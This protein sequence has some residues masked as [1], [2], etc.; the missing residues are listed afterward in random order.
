MIFVTGAT[1]VGV[2]LGA[3][4]VQFVARNV[5]EWL[6]LV[7]G[8]ASLFFIIPGLVAIW[9]SGDTMLS[10]AVSIPLA[11]VCLVCGIGAVLKSYRT[12]RV[13]LGIGLAAIP[14]LLWIVFAIGGVRYPH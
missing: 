4:I 10:P 5:L 6:V 3:L 12:W 14:S 11:V 13:W 1:I 9:I 2:I 8:A 7:L